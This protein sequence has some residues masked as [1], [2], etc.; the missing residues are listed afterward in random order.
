VT[1]GRTESDRHESLKVIGLQK[2]SW[3]LI[4]VVEGYPWEANGHEDEHHCST[5]ASTRSSSRLEIVDRAR[6]TELQ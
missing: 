1:R 4:A 6:S 2:E 3:H 5:G